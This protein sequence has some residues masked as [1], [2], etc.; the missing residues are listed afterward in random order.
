M[1]GITIHEFDALVA[2]PPDALNANELHSVPEHVFS[3]LESQAL[4]SVE[5]GDSAWL[6]LTQRRGHRAVQVTSFVGVIR[7]PD[8]FQI[9]VLPKVGKAIDGGDVQARQLLIEMLRCLGGFRHIQTDSAKL[10]AA[11]MPLLEVFIGEFLLTVE[12]IVK[13]GLR[14]HYTLRQDN[15]FALRGKLQMA[16]HLR[17]NLCRRDRF[18]SEFDEFSNNRPENR[19]LHSALRQALAWTSSQTHQQLAR[20]L[21]FVFAEIPES[22]QQI[23][24]FQRV[25]LDRGMGHYADALAWARLILQDESP[26]TGAGGHRAPSLLFPMAAV[27]EAYVAKHLARQ[28]GQPFTLRAQASSF[29]L[30]RHQSQDWF[31][32]KPD[33]L[34]QESAANRL[35][36]DT[37]WKLIDGTKA[38]GTDKYGLSQGDFYQLYAYGQTYL[39]GQGDV[40]LIYPKT[41]AFERALPMFEF[42]KSRGL[43]LWVLPFCLQ[44]RRLV[45]PA[46]GSLDAFARGPSP[47][48]GQNAVTN[49]GLEEMALT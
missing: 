49:I 26:L 20:E 21:C 18:F 13:R 35:V 23:L 27:F 16:A 25:R 8:G 46:C 44:Q 15:I 40:V 10:V 14:G 45:L 30:I 11:H 32:M 4:R 2:L 47:L 41:D 42:P 38:N 7:A 3:W 17:Q 36:L 34:I 19:L 37:K 39:D 1:A 24:D 22:E 5:A 43:R 31:R 29:S 6:R 28:L 33:L 12:H 48:T 9:E